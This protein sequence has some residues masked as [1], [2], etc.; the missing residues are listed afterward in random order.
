MAEIDQSAQSAQSARQQM[1]DAIA[2]AVT[3]NGGVESSFSNG[4]SKHVMQNSISF[5]QLRT[6]LAA[7]KGNDEKAF[8]GTLKDKLVFSVNFNFETAE[9]LK[10]G[11]VGNNAGKKRGR[12]VNEEV[13]QAA[14]ERVKRGVSQDDMDNTALENARNALY[15]LLTSLRGARGEV[16]IESWALSFKKTEPSNAKQQRPQLILSSRLTPAVAIHLK[17]LFR[18][19]GPNCR[20]D[21]MLTIDSGM[22]SNGLN[23]PLSEH[24]L[25]SEEY[26]Q[27][28]LTMFATVMGNNGLSA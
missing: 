27:R 4:V 22:V 7:T 18:L 21:G 12:D 26:G 10:V 25:T 9:P 6:V 3:K 16:A 23:L 15:S 2:E 13:V 28:S 17:T 19:M 5:S 20:Q 24:A 14:V 1:H 11:M 8:L